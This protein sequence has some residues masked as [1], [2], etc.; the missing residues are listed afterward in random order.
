MYKFN[1]GFFIKLLHMA[2]LWID[3]NYQEML[4]FFHQNLAYHNDNIQFLAMTEISESTWT[5]WRK[6]KKI[7]FGQ[8]TYNLNP[9]MQ[10]HIQKLEKY[11]Q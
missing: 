10:H 7:N 5:E 4:G 8:F 6:R 11:I 1:T 9:N 2:S 3:S